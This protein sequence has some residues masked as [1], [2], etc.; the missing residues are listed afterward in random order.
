MWLTARYRGMR[1]ATS[2]QQ[3]VILDITK[4]LSESTT[5]GY[6]PFWI[7]QD[8]ALQPI[9]HSPSTENSLVP[10]RIL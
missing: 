5:L 3:V 7:Y 10:C 8:P 1:L 9:L 2:Q 4:L 6:A